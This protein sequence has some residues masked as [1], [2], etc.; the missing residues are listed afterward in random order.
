[1]LTVAVCTYNRCVGLDKTLAS[2]VSAI[3]PEHSSVEIIVVNNNSADATPQIIEKYAAADE[4]IKGIFA[5][6]Q[7]HS[8]ARNA[9][10]EAARGEYIA[11]TDDDVL[12][13]ENWLVDLSK[14]IDEEHPGC[15]GGKVLPLWESVRPDWLGPEFYPMLALLDF[16]SDRVRLDIPK[17]WGANMCLSMDVVRRNGEFDVAKGRN[18]TRLSSGDDTDYILRLIKNGERVLY[19][20]APTVWHRIGPDRVRKSYFRKWRYDNARNAARQGANDSSLGPQFAGALSRLGRQSCNWRICF[21]DEK[22]RL[23]NQLE[24]MSAVGRVMGLIDRIWVRRQKP[25]VE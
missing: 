2:I 12:V 18:G 9:A 19:D 14:V 3:R 6:E 25:G 23:L 7:G 13:D 11:F 17:V 5:R 21:G 20:P 8:H 4:R 15:V 1:M 16:H 10:I 22:S 24:L